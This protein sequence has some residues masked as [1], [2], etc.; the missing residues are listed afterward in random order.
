MNIV[1]VYRFED[2][3]GNAMCSVP[4]TNVDKKVQLYLQDFNSLI[5]SGVDPR[6]RLSNGQILER[7]KAK[8]SITRLVAKAKK[9]EKIR[10]LDGDAC[11]LRRDNLLK[12]GGGGRK[13]A[14]ENLSSEN[15]HRFHQVKLKY[16]DAPLPAWLNP[17]L[18]K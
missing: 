15:R 18:V 5:E 8:L 3:D 4:L 14:T 7:G 16:I 6:W 2:E 13:D 17:E 11:N 9:G 1:E 12:T 10:L